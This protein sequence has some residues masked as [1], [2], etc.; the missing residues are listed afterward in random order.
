MWG[1]CK[2]IPNPT[3]VLAWIHVNGKRQHQKW[4]EPQRDAAREFRDIF[5]VP[6]E[7]EENEDTVQNAKRK[8]GKTRG[9]E[10]V[11]R[12]TMTPSELSPCF[13]KM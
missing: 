12:A 5:D 6:T 13:S 3:D 9:M 2:I 11:A 4:E 1:K 10:H 8:L 7:E